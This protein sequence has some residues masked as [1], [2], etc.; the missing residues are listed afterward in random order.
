M[1]AYRSVNIICCVGFLLP[2]RADRLKGK[3]FL[4]CEV[5]GQGRRNNHGDFCFRGSGVDLI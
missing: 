5:G 2:Q 4:G 1:P 3:Q